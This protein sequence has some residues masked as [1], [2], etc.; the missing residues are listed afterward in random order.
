[1]KICDRNCCENKINSS[2]IKWLIEI[3]GPVILGSKPAEILN[4][5]C[6][7]NNKETK[8]NDIK[9]FFSNCS[10]L[11]YEIINIQDGGVRIVFINKDSLSK[12]LSNK[13]CLNFLKFVGYPSNY[14]LDKYINVL[15]DKLNTKDFPHEIGIFLGY[16]LKDVVGFMGYGKYKFCKTRYWRVYGDESISDNVYNQFISD[17]AK[18]KS[19][20]ENNSLSELKKV[21]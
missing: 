9:S 14:D 16:P 18:I 21:I 13:K 10:R 6:K 5:S 12:V 4:L 1:M 7:D 8:L 3:L 2:Y 15:I 20:L 19:L 11:S 17:R